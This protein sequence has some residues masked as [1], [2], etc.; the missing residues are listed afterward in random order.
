[1]AQQRLVA[2]VGSAL[3]DSGQ[4]RIGHPNEIVKKSCGS[5]GM[6]PKVAAQ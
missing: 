5:S 1:M 6:S 3:V 2:K 4:T